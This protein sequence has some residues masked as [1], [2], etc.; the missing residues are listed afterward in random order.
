VT[1]ARVG[2]QLYTLRGECARDLEGVLRAVGRL[3]YEGVELFDLHGHAPEQVRAWLDEAGLAVAGR[4]A[5]IELLE[6]D[7]PGLAAEL[8]TLGTDRVALGWIDA[9]VT[10]ATA[11]AWVERIATVGAR[12]AELGLRF[13]FHNHAGEL[14]SLEDG[15][16]LLDLLAGLAPDLLWLELDLGWVWEAGVDPVELLQRLQG[17]T[18][19]VHVKDFRE[20]GGAAFCPVGDGAVG[21]PRIVPAADAAGVEW[22]VV[23]QDEVDGSPLEAVERS[24]R[25]VRKMLAEAA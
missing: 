14:R 20:H 15:G 22:L 12:A 6:S 9:P 13:G 10:L 2:L 17:R 18:P 5:G 24:I 1:S 8:R 25:A 16:T 21:Y 23:E 7:L 3:G 19:L 11:R 4:H